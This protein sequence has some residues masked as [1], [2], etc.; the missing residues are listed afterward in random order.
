MKV[1][2]RCL[3]LDLAFDIQELFGVDLVG[4]DVF[5]QLVCLNTLLQVLLSIK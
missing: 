5:L 2:V 1:L 4:T 3:T